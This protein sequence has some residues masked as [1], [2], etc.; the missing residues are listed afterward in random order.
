MRAVSEGRIR[1][2][3]PRMNQ[4]PL[5]PR[6]HVRGEERLGCARARERLAPRESWGFWR[7]SS[8]RRGRFLGA[9]H[10]LPRYR[11]GHRVHRR[12]QSIVRVVV[13]V[14]KRRVRRG[15]DHGMRRRRWEARPELVVEERP[16]VRVRGLGLRG[17][18][19]G[20]VLSRPPAVPWLALS[21]TARQ[22]H[23]YAS[24]PARHG[25]GEPRLCARRPS[26]FP[27]CLRR[28]FGR[29]VSQFV[30]KTQST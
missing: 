12:G 9:R 15:R 5:L 4:L 11:H 29:V 20:L 27:G 3:P 30:S 19:R 10:H 7:R 22:L 14:V 13:R 16:W 26:N 2:G 23:G 8:R 21:V 18:R 1:H 6:V 24:R 25:G 28:G 17:R